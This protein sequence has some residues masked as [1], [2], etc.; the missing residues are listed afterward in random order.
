MTLPS[1]HEEPIAKSHR[2]EEFDCGDAKMNEFLLRFAQQSHEQNAS[3]T[4]CAIDDTASDRILGFYT[5]APS[6][7][8]HATVP[9]AMTRGLA[10]HGSE[11]IRLLLHHAFTELNFH[12]I[13]IR[14]LAYNE[15]A[16]RA[17]QK[18]GFLIEGRERETAFVD[19]LWHDFLQP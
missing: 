3:K 10:R 11:A 13:G 18:C 17:Y 2:R 12:R 4:F 1:W 5:I 14:V 15:R 8:E 16:I 19:G 6:A 9:D 7:V